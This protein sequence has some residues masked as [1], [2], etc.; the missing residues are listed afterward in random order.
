MA[1][2]L[3]PGLV[4]DA[5]NQR[6]VAGNVGV[7]IASTGKSWPEAVPSSARGAGRGR[8]CW[9]VSCGASPEGW[10]GSNHVLEPAAVYGQPRAGYRGSGYTGSSATDA[11]AS[12]TPPIQIGKRPVTVINGNQPAANVTEI[13]YGMGVEV[14]DRDRDEDRQRDEGVIGPAVR[15]QQGRGPNLHQIRRTRGVS[16][17]RA[18]DYTPSHT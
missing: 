11:R 8:P 12:L 2:A 15:S 4:A 10:P 18:S 3:E 9:R 5:P 14:T 1:G 6:P 17:P 7:V 13:R 16:S